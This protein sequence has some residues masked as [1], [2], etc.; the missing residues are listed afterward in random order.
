MSYTR[1]FVLVAMRLA[2]KDSPV[3]SVGLHA[4]THHKLIRLITLSHPYSWSP[5]QN[6]RMLLSWIHQA[7]KIDPAGQTLPHDTKDDAGKLIPKGDPWPNYWTMVVKVTPADQAD[8]ITFEKH[9]DEPDCVDIAYGTGNPKKGEIWL[10]VTALKPT[11]SIIKDGKTVRRPTGAQIVAKYK[12][13]PVAQA[14]IYVI[15]PGFLDLSPQPIKD[16]SVEPITFTRHAEYEG[17]G[18]KPDL[19]QHMAPPATFFTTNFYYHWIE[20]KVLDQ[21]GK[22]LGDF[23]SGTTVA[24][25]PTWIAWSRGGTYLDPVGNVKATFNIVY[26]DG[27]AVGLDFYRLDPN[28]KLPWIDHIAH[29]LS[30]AG[31]HL[32]NGR[33][34][35]RLLEIKDGE[36]PAKYPGPMPKKL[37]YTLSWEQ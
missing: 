34:I 20:M 4:S 7:P 5:C 6:R 16:D 31:W 25:G 15:R 22:P 21:Y 33:P 14:N 11:T 35:K 12:G 27:I 23:Y 30:V 13:A 28:A 1:I 32:N 29:V 2:S 17:P 24:E 37:G 36:R 10:Q 19:P 26:K 9:G 18:V 8:Q 3:E